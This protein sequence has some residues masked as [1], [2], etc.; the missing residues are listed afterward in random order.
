MV[1]KQ[2]SKRA[3]VPRG[4]KTSELYYIEEDTE[5]MQSQ[6]DD[7]SACS[8]VKEYSEPGDR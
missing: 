7:F 1:T 3:E 5:G 4:F 8:D 6:K 2:Q